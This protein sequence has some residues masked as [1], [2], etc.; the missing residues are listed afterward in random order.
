MTDRCLDKLRE[1][2]PLIWPMMV[3][4][5]FRALSKALSCSYRGSD[6]MFLRTRVNSVS[7]RRTRSSASFWPIEPLSPNSLPI[8]SRVSAG[9]GVVSWTL[10]GVSFRATIS[11][12]LL[13]TRCS[14]KPKNQPIEVLPRW[15][16]PAN[17]LCR[18]RRWVSQTGRAVESIEFIPI[19]PL[20]ATGSG[21]PGSYAGHSRFPSRHHGRPASTGGFDDATA[22]DTAVDMLDP[23]STIVEHLVGSL[24]R[25]W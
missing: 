17:T 18:L 16:R 20:A 5:M 25:Q 10:P 4:A 11:L 24:L 6:F 3:S 8:R 7:P 13:K 19:K 23:Q 15:A 9:T 1:E 12:S 2:N 22:L 14:L 21:G